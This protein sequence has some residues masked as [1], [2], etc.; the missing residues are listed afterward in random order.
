MKRPIVLL[1]AAVLLA[2]CN[3]NQTPPGNDP[4]IFG[5]QTVPPPGTG[6]VAG[7]PGDP[8]YRGAPAVASSSPPGALTPPSVSLPP[9][10]SGSATRDMAPAASSTARS[11]APPSAGWSVPAAVRAETTVTPRGAAASAAT[12][13][14]LGTYPGAP[15]PP[16]SSLA[17]SSPSAIRIPEPSAGSGTAGGSTSGRTTFTRTLAPRPATATPATP[18]GYRPMPATPPGKPIDIMTLPR[19][20]DS[21]SSTSERSSAGESGLRF[22]SD[23]REAGQPDRVVT[24]DG[25][26]A[27]DSDATDR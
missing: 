26:T 25:A 11:A 20:G 23:A 2:G 9:A 27:A 12:A 16:A 13:R 4:F 6:A 24:A 21:N 7:R 8:S 17:A 3:K 18:A 15:S 22:A 1:L 14:T 5:R 19:V 10:T